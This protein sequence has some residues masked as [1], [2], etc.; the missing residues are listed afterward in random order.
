MAQSFTTDSHSYTNLGFT[1][2]LANP[3]ATN[4]GSFSVGLYSGDS[5]S[6]GSLIG[7]LTTAN[8]T[9]FT[10]PSGDYFAFQ[11]ILFTNNTITLAANTT[12][13]VGVSNN[14][15]Q[16]NAF[17]WESLYDI[18]PTGVGAY[19]KGISD[20]SQYGGGTSFLPST[21]PFNLTVTGTIAV[22]EPS[23]CA[24]FCIGTLGIIMM[25]LRRKKIS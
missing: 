10:N 3:A 15:D 4:M 17:S 1:L 9:F 18:T 24:L 11:N 6:M 12:Y 22:P 2:N 8:A 25:V 14:P 7:S 21:G 23:T 20:Y 5:N 16:D 13:W 19:G